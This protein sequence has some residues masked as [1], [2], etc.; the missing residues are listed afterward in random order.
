[1]SSVFNE[2]FYLTNNADV[3]LAVSQGTFASAQQHFDLFGGRELRNP[4]STFD[5]NY[6]SVQNQ[7]VLQAVSSGVFANAFAH[8][9]SFGIEENRAPTVSFA[10]FDAASYLT[11]N[12]DVAAAVTAGT[13][14]SAL[15]HFMSFG[16]SEGRSG[17]GITA[18]PTNPGT[19]FT[20]EATS[21]NIVGTSGDDQ[22]NG[23]VV[24]DG[25]TGSTLLAGDILG[26][27]AG[28]DTVDIAVSGDSGTNGH[29][30]QAIQ[31]TG[32]ETITLSNFD[33]DATGTTT[34]DT[35]LLNDSLVTVGLSA[36]SAT[37]DTAFTGMTSV[38]GA[39]MKNG[40][41]D[42]TMTYSAAAVAGTADTQTL[43]VSNISAG[44]FSC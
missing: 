11:A 43:A 9:Q 44:T 12:T 41:A 6:Y 42:L 19:T 37:G 39:Q 10:G 14:S 23:V 27:G 33:T 13:I 35:T 26:G 38:V 32:I 8:F 5:T 28:A 16:S 29:T 21:D 25:A 36:S 17:S 4:N 3:V 22:I 30:I 7:D 34:F 24:G 1:M 20:L 2:N 15:E 18:V 31:G 40:S